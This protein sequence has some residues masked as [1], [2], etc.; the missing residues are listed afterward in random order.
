MNFRIGGKVVCVRSHSLGVITKGQVFTIRGL[1]YC[2]GCGDQYIDV[3]ITNPGWG[4]ITCGHCGSRQTQDGGLLISQILF[5]PIE[6]K[7]ETTYEEIITE[8]VT[9]KP[10]EFLN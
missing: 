2:R 10:I 6:E 8:M 3:G 4:E 7:G 9:Q 1:D 5:A